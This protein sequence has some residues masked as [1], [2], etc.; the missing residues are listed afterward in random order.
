[1]RACR[2]PPPRR[3]ATQGHRRARPQ[4][5]GAPIPPSPA[6]EDFKAGFKAATATAAGVPASLVKIKAVKKGSVVVDFE[7]E[8]MARAACLYGLYGLH[9]LPACT[10][11]LCGLYG[12]SACTACAACTACPACPPRTRC[13]PTAVAGRQVPETQA[14]AIDTKMA[15]AVSAGIPV[16]V[17]GAVVTGDVAAPTKTTNTAAS[18]KASGYVAP[19]R[20]TGT[21]T[22]PKTSV[23]S[24][25]ALPFAAMAFATVLLC[26]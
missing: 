3:T 17:N 7:I 9:G 1:V 15:A 21:G 6:L 20:G 19:A 13:A 22:G 5:A 8:V 26:T 18:R 12:L 10:Y 25:T 11:G 23:A 24:T 16:T 14:A 2:R 4:A